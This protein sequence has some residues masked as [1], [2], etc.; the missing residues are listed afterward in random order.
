MLSASMVLETT[1]QNARRLHG[2]YVYAYVHM[3][4]HAHVDA[5][6]YLQVAEARA[7]LLFYQRL[8][9]EG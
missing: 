7:Y 3:H 9:L 6:V 1:M 4:V 2:Q 8:D 5:R